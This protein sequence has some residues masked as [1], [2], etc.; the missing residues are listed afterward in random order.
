MSA[1]LIAVTVALTALLAPAFAHLGA[2]AAAALLGGPARRRPPA[3]P[4]PGAGPR[5]L[6]VVPAHDEEGSIAATVASLRAVAYDPAR[7]AVV[8][9]ADN[10]ADAT[11]RVARDAGAAVVER[12]DPARR[13]K[14]YALEDFFGGALATPPG[15][16]PGDWDAAV[17]VDADTVVDPGLPAAVAAAGAA[18]A[19]AAARAP[20][21]TATTS[22]SPSP[23]RRSP[24]TARRRART[25]KA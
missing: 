21:R 3:P 12:S 18:V 6:V 15:A 16:G 10:C 7:L 24:R 2:L 17:V 20:R 25:A 22:T 11:A 9:L 13:S 4:P 5:L 19:V 8:V 14:G 1:V 23:P